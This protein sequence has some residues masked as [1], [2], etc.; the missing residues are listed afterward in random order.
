MANQ[1]ISVKAQ[2]PFLALPV[3]KQIEKR[4]RVV[5]IP[6]L[7]I[8]QEIQP[9]IRRQH[10]I[11]EVPQMQISWLDKDM[12]VPKLN[13]VENVVEVPVEVGEVP[14]Y[15]PTWEELHVPRIYPY[16]TGDRKEIQVDVP[17]VQFTDE[18]QY[19]EKIIG[20]VTKRQPKYVYKN[21]PVYKYVDVVKDIDEPI[22]VIRYKPVYN[23]E[24]IVEPP[25]VVPYPEIDTQRLEPVVA[26]S[27]AMQ[28]LLDQEK[29]KYRD[30]LDKVDSLP[31]LPNARPLHPER[32][33]KQR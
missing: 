32:H 24:L 3:R 11:H 15:V 27:T 19:K 5:T 8:K 7:C 9:V 33:L 30:L 4:D 16:Y 2:Q 22:D 18:K 23:V 25:I 29:V 13:V 6:K 20:E 28:K 14:R 21:I 10:I 12:A 31:E 1:T 26:D 17:K